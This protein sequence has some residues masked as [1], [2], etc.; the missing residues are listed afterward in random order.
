MSRQR[1]LPSLTAARL[2]PLVHS[3]AQRSALPPRQSQAHQAQQDGDGVIGDERAERHR[4]VLPQAL[5]RRGKSEA[6]G[7]G[8]VRAA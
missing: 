4:L 1:Q 5:L 3:A 7:Q 2:Q 6:E 8:S